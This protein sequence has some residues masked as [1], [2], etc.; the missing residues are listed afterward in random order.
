MGS[1]A[2]AGGSPTYALE[3]PSSTPSFT[4]LWETTWDPLYSTT[5]NVIVDSGVIILIPQFCA[6]LSA[7][8]HSGMIF[9][10]V[11]GLALMLMAAG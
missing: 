4:Q 3:T 8:H 11:E 9:L 5:D 2:Q 1:Q 7:D 6:F 10:L